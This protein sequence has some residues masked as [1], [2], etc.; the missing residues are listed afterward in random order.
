MK[1]GYARVSTDEQSLHVQTQQLKDAGCKVVFGENQS[2]KSAERQILEKVLHFLEQ[3]A[4]PSEALDADVLVVTKLDRLARSTSDLLAIV[5]RIRKA[6]PS[7]FPWRNR[8][9]IPPHRLA[10]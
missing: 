10:R 4:M 9:R 2:G 5:D 6:A 3:Q 8:G 7:F 1:I